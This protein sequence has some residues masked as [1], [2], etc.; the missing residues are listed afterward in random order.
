M[1]KKRQ[2][3]QRNYVAYDMIVRSQ[4]AG[5]HT[6][7]RKEA[8]RTACRDPIDLEEWDDETPDDDRET[9]RD[10]LSNGNARDKSS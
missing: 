8:D 4:K 7:L 2:P 1:A 5:L 3:K 6:D 9:G 10:I